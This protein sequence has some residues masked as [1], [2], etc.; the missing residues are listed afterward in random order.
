MNLTRFTYIA[1]PGVIAISIYLLISSFDAVDP[2]LADE[3]EEGGIDYDAWSEGIST[4]L[5]DEQ[6]RINYTLEAETQIHRNDDSTELERPVVQLFPAEGGRWNISANS[7]RIL[8]ALAS[9]SD[10]LELIQLLGQVRVLHENDTGLDTE[11]HTDFLNIDT[12]REIAET[13]RD[14]TLLSDALQQTATG[15]VAHFRRDEIV[16]LS[17]VRGRY[18]P[19]VQ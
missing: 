5:Y 1:V 4:V 13:D 11:L 15:M 16:F 10:S 9:G 18:D 19:T 12:A 6:G 17:N 3:G 7:G 14:V 8:G 2:R